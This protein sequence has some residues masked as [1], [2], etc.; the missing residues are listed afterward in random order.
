MS[1]NA[2]YIGDKATFAIRYMPDF[3]SVPTEQF[4]RISH[5]TFCHFVFGGQLIGIE[6]ENCYLSTWKYAFEW[7][8]DL[9]KYDFE[10]LSSPI[11][12]DRTDE[13]LWDLMGLSYKLSREMP[14]KKNS[15]TALFLENNDRTALESIADRCSL[16]IDETTD[17]FVLYLMSMGDDIKFI[18]KKHRGRKVRSITV[19]RDFVVE[20]ME[21]C[22]RQIETDYP[23]LVYYWTTS[24]KRRRI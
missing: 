20:T 22:I 14:F 15:R 10:K 4:P 6:D 12:T 17:R 23:D 24:Y 19:R 7:Y 2:L 5:L 16:S 9:I 13:E 3:S 18:W 11:F 8:T 21:A 1:K